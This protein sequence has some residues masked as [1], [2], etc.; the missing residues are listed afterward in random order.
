ML[1]HRYNRVH[2]L[3]VGSVIVVHTHIFVEQYLLSRDSAFFCSIY[4]IMSSRHGEVSVS[5]SVLPMSAFTMS[6][7]SVEFKAPCAL[8]V[9]AFNWTNRLNKKVVKVIERTLALRSR[10]Q[11]W[12]T[13][14]MSGGFLLTLRVIHF[15]RIRKIG[16]SQCLCGCQIIRLVYLGN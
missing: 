14:K 1:L 2:M 16:R 10:F 11:G 9:G 7:A 5:V 12:M 13:A 3:I 6:S 15:F 8:I 4:I